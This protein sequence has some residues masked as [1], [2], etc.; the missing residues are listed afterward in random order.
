M[1]IVFFD[2]QGVMVTS[3]AVDLTMMISHA[4]A[5]TRDVV[6]LGEVFALLTM[7]ID[8]SVLEVLLV[9]F[10]QFLAP[11]TPERRMS[12]LVE[13]LVSLDHSV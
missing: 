1:S 9:F 8:W 6:E 4:W 5:D 7:K 2:G 12:F 13:F 11:S 10:N 3:G